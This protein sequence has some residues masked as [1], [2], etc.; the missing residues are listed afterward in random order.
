MIEASLVHVAS[1]IFYKWYSLEEKLAL[2]Q[3]ESSIAVAM[4]NQVEPWK[5]Q[6]APWN[7]EGGE[8]ATVASNSSWWSEWCRKCWRRLGQPSRVLQDILGEEAQRG[9]LIQ[10]DECNLEAIH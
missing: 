10:S 8:E 7:M 2:N 3:M 4:K 9:N 6:R 5:N 1:C